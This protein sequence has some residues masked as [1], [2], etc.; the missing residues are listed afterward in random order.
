M[1]DQESIGK[2]GPGGLSGKPIHP[3]SKEIVSYI[4]QKTSGN[5]PIIAVGGIMDA[6][7]AIEMLN[8]GASLVQIYTGFVYNGPS[9]VKSINSKILESE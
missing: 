7:H 6:N 8:A 5:L 1:T 9:I 4:F 3:I 2:K